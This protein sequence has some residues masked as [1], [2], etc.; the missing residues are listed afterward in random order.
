M[1]QKDMVIGVTLAETEFGENT[2]DESIWDVAN[3][4]IDDDSAP[5]FETDVDLPSAAFGVTAV[6]LDELVTAMKAVASDESLIVLG[7]LVTDE[8][9]VIEESVVVVESVTV[10]HV[11]LRNSFSTISFEYCCLVNV[12]LDSQR[13][14]MQHLSLMS[15]FGIVVVCSRSSSLFLIYL[16]RLLYCVVAIFSDR[17]LF[18]IEHP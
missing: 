4:L 2:D 10:A 1:S 14:W 12:I 17:R 11:I 16:I 9:A 13:H 3:D 7:Q 8:A 18:C 6:V 5:E 15:M